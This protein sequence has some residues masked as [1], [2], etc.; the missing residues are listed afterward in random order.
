MKLIDNWRMIMW[1]RWSTWLAGFNAILVAYVFSQPAIVIGLLG[2][3]PGGWQI[4]LAVVL[5]VLAFGLPVLV[6]H[7]QQ[8]KLDAKIEEKRNGPA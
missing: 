2:F 7:I 5:A 3:A 4:P 8:P 1:R 6:A